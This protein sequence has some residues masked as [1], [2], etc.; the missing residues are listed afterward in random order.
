MIKNRKHGHVG[1]AV[2]D[3][4]KEAEWYMEVLGF[5]KIGEFI[6]PNGDTVIFLQG[7]DIVY[8]IFPEANANQERKI[9]H[10]AF[11]SDD[12]EADYQYCLDKGYRITTDGIE[13]IPTFWENGV[14]YFKI[15]SAGQV[16]I[17]FC[18][19]I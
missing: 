4:K 13:E 17:E 9:D 10:Y 15:E 12:I 2:A 3:V 5:A 6:H 11:E 19:A 1:I 8:E 14:K 7:K 18:Q 16:Q